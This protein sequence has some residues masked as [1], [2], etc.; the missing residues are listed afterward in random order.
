LL[1]VLSSAGAEL[2]VV[3]PLVLAVLVLVVPVLVLVLVPVLAL[4]VCS[5]S[6]IRPV[7]PVAPVEPQPPAGLAGPAPVPR[8]A[9]SGLKVDMIS[10]FC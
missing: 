10:L 6:A 7:G 9:G 1:V 3:G 5:G 4:L 8:L 2:L